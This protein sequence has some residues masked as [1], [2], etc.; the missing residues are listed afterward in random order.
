MGTVCAPPP[1][2]W[3][4]EWHPN[5]LSQTVQSLAACWGSAAA[6]YNCCR[7]LLQIPLHCWYC[8]RSDSPAEPQEQAP[9]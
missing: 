2:P 1:V 7:L 6:E 8:K 3:S 4:C 5:F 9:V